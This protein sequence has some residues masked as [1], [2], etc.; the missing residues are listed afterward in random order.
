[1]NHILYNEQTFEIRLDAII[2]SII[3]KYDFSLRCQ[4]VDFPIECAAP[5]SFTFTQ[6]RRLRL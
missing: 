6:Q 3:M 4:T 2:F 1:M 5:E